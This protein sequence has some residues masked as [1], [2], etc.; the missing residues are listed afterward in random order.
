MPSHA[1]HAWGP[2]A[3]RPARLD[4]IAAVGAY[5]FVLAGIGRLSLLKVESTKLLMSIQLVNYTVFNAL[6][7]LNIPSVATF[8]VTYCNIG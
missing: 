7:S 4:P 5:I 1:T 3:S 8:Y 6:K 2:L